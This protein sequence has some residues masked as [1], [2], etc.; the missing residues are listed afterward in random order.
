MKRI[1]LV[2]SVLLICISCENDHPVEQLR[3]TKGV[4]ITNLEQDSQA[5]ELFGKIVTHSKTGKLRDQLEISDIYNYFDL[6]KDINNYTVTLPDT[7]DEYFDNLVVSKI[8]DS[9]FGFI[10]RYRPEKGYVSENGFTGVIERFNLEEELIGTHEIPGNGV[11]TIQ[12]GS[13]GRQKFISQCIVGYQSYCW[14]EYKVSTATGL[15]LPETVTTVCASEAVYG[16]CGDNAGPMPRPEDNGWGTYIPVTTGGTNSSGSQA[17][18][19]N[20]N[21]VP[22]KLPENYKSPIVIVEDEHAL[23]SKIQFLLDKWENSNIDD[24]E[25]NKCM[26]SIVTALKNVS[27]GSLEQIIQKFSGDTPGFNWKLTNGTLPG[28]NRAVTNSNYNEVNGIVTTTFDVGK[29]KKSTDLSIARTILHEAIH[30]YLVAYFKVDESSARKTFSILMDDY[31]KGVYANQNQAQHAE[32]AR[33]FISQIALA[34]E[35]FGKSKGYSLSKQFYEDL[36][37]GGLTHTGEYDSSGVPIE[38]SWFKSAIPN[39]TDRK[40]IV[41]VVTIEQTGTTLQGVPKSQKGINANC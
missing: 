25:L 4:V 35:D 39:A 21:I 20:L 30:A 33:N 17:D 7:T 32:F 37:W 23:S 40:R 8:G 6:D 14:Q 10:L 22:T 12:T 1:S 5:R 13:H 28:S 19:D 15:P 34:L 24:A 11:N 31:E 29:L 3:Q 38:S 9:Y 2:L 16:W 27:S 26:Q 36:A 41:D 18:P